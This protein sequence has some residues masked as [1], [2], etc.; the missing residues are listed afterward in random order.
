MRR[1][2]RCILPETY[3]EIRFDEEGVCNYCRSYVPAAYKG[4]DALQ[5][6]LDAHPSGSEWDCLVPLSGGRDSTYTLLQLVTKYGRRVLVYNY[7]NG[8]VEKV[9][10]DNIRAIAERLKVDVVSRA[11][12]NDAQ[13]RLA[14]HLT[15]MNLRKS[16][17]HVMTALCSG[18][19]NGI[20]GGAYAVARE[21]DIPLVIFGESS[22][23][24][25]VFKRKYFPRFTP[26]S[27]EKALFMLKMPINFLQRKQAARL[28]NREFPLSPADGVIRQIN[29]FD[30]EEWNEKKILSAIQDRLEWRHQ[31]G[32]STWRFDCQIHAL[33]NRM[34]YRLIGMTEKDELY[35]KMIREGQIS[36]YEA[37]EKISGKGMDAEQEK[38]VINAVLDRLQ[39]NEKEKGKILRFCYGVSETGN[40]W[41]GQ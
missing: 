32:Q 11:S 5:E 20:W 18:C 13:C 3:P 40:A 7:D 37:L 38:R 26:S 31:A 39:L 15:R 34:T 27:F 30:Y 19:R 17:A 9:A 23:E 4:E 21:R 28:I 22:M 14:R 2:T 16:P 35:S 6:L 36:R 33:V 29:F 41:D 24:S 10:K 8:F 12:R 25:G 1:C